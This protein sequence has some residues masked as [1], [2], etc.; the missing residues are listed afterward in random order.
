MYHVHT[1]WQLNLDQR[2]LINLV[3]KKT[4]LFSFLNKTMV[5]LVSRWRNS[6]LSNRYLSTKRGWW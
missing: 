6:C 5:L 2:D 1:S 3:T 4:S